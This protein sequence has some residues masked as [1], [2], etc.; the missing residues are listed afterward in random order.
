MK[1]TTETVGV[2]TRNDMPSN[3]PFSSGI[4]SANGP[5]RAGGGRDDVQRGGAGVAQVLVA[6]V[7][8]ALELV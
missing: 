8:Q 1:S 6:D 7:Q 3:L 2:G 5:G 4:T